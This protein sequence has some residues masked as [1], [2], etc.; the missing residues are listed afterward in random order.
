M[1]I[2][3]LERH[4]YFVVHFWNPEKTACF[5]GTGRC[6]PHPIAFDSATRICQYRILHFDAPNT[7]W[8]T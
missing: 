4:K 7:L 5:A 1:G 8:I 6:N 3:I 2:A